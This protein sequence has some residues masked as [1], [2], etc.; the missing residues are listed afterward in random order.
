MLPPVHDGFVRISSRWFPQDRVKDYSQ[1]IAEV[2]LYT[3]AAQLTT[4][5]LMMYYF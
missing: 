4:L 3:I 1:V 2:F 5:P